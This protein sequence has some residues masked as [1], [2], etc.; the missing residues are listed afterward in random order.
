MTVRVLASTNKWILMDFIDGLNLREFLQAERSKNQQ[1]PLLRVKL[2][3]N[4]GKLLLTALTQLSQANLHHEDLAPSNIIVHQG[5]DGS[6]DHLTLIDIGRNYLYTRHVGI[7]TSREASFVAPEIKAGQKTEDTSDM[8]SFGMILIELADPLGVQGKS[9]PDSLY[10]YAPY[11][12]RFIE[13]LIDANPA[14]R[15]LIFPIKDPKDPYANLCQIFEDLLKL[16][17]PENE[18]K[19]S[20][21]AWLHQFRQF[22][23]PARQRKQAWDLWRITKSSS[24]H[25][26]IAKHTGWLFWWLFVSMCTSWAIFVLSVVW[27]TRDLGMNPFLPFYIS[28]PQTLIRGCGGICLPFQNFFYSY[29][30]QNIPMRGIGLSIGLVQSA[31]Y[32]NILAGLTTR[33]MRGRLA[34]FTECFLRLQTLVAFPLIAIGNLVEPGWWLALLI[35]G[36]PVPAL[37]NF[38]CYNLATRTFKEARAAKISTA[39]PGEDPSLSNFG[40]WGT[41][42]FAYIIVLCGIWTGLHFDKLFD[43]WAYASVIFVINVVALCISKSI[44]QAPPVRGSLSRAFTLGERLAVLDQKSR[45]NISKP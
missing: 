40:S 15:R 17:P 24:T 34:G 21:F 14:N 38:F 31:Y 35:I 10:R 32:P 18:M 1:P 45:K 22:L 12:A 33:L 6:I 43:V 11:L 37:V 27:G 2:L 19:P 9:I 36:L 26:E 41:M 39:P 23:D 4:I 8:Y 5:P 3:A 7:E 20:K 28:I 16:L 44:V 30:V 25:P 13:D 29:G 42:L